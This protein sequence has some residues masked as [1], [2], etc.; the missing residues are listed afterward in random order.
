M[1]EKHPPQQ[2]AHTV[3]VY[4]KSARLALGPPTLKVT[5]ALHPSHHL[6]MLPLC[7]ADCMSVP[8]VLSCLPLQI[9]QTG[10][11]LQQDD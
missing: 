2:A 5:P 7:A 3:V 9:P 8:E 6:R 1:F 10:R 4:V 11:A